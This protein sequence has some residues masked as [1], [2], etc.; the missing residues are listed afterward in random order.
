MDRIIIIESLSTKCDA[1][2]LGQL[3]G[4]FNQIV[5][6]IGPGVSAAAFLEHLIEPM[7]L[8]Q[9]HGDAG[10]GDQAVLFLC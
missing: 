10:I 5:S 8:Q 7:F 4:K 1:G 2:V 6:P 3:R 9:L